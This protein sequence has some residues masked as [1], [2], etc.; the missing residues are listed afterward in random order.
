M[1]GQVADIMI[2]SHHSLITFR[3]FGYL[4]VGAEFTYIF[5]HAWLHLE[6]HR[7]VALNGTTT[8]VQDIIRLLF[9]ICLPGCILKQLVNV[10]QLASACYAIAE[11]DALLK[12]QQQQEATTKKR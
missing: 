3:F 1:T 7:R 2:V 4:C 12:R 8:F 11:R 9:W 5:A 6:G 10:A